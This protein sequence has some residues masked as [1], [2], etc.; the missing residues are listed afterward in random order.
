M[1]RPI[2]NLNLDMEIGGTATPLN[3]VVEF[4][5]F[6]PMPQVF[7]EAAFLRARAALSR[8]APRVALPRRTL[9]RNEIDPLPLPG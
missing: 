2:Y 8:N 9:P 7:D 4:P 5:T 1:P 3:W 6:P